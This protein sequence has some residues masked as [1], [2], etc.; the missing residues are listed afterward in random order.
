MIN[1]QNQGTRSAIVTDEDQSKN[2]IKI[3]NKTSVI[4]EQE[5]SSTN[6]MGDVHKSKLDPYLREKEHLERQSECKFEITLSKSRVLEEL[7]RCMR[8]NQVLPLFGL[9]SDVVAS[10][11][12]GMKKT[13]VT[14]LPH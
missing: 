14:T 2:M 1:M 7:K 9:K 5:E 4:T 10:S 3:V 11:H 8:V 12:A 13:V 6:S